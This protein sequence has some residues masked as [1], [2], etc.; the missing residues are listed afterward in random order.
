MMVLASTLSPVALTVL[1]AAGYVIATLG[2]KAVVLGFALSG[3]TAILAGLALAAWSEIALMRVTELSVLYVAVLGAE[4][5]LI[6]AIATGLGEG[7]NLRQ[8]MGAALVVGG[9]V[10]VG[11]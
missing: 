3:M 11:A 1:T 9:L 10:L 6:L 7:L 5:L 8:G 2:M 4:T